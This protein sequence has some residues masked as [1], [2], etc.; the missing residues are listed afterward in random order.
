MIYTHHHVNISRQDAIYFQTC[1]RV[2]MYCYMMRAPGGS[3]DL[4]VGIFVEIFEIFGN[5]S[6]LLF[7][8][9]RRFLGF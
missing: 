7:Y 8:F 6:D 2:R 1:M 3:A 9:L 4:R 5:I